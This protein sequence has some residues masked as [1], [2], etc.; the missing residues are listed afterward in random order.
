MSTS[1]LY[2]VKHKRTG[3]YYTPVRKVRKG[4]VHIKSNLAK[5]GKI[6]HGL[7]HARKATQHNFFR[8]ENGEMENV[9]NL[10]IVE[11]GEN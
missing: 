3:M 9:D 2:R 11:F 1:K 10:S 7:H 6:Y 4:G 8:N 5:G